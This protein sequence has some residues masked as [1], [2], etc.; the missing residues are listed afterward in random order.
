MPEIDHV[1]VLMLEN[2]SFDHILGFLDHPD[3]GFD[4]VRGIGPYV[5]PGWENNPEVP[6]TPTAKTVI[7]V[8]PDH[9]HAGVMEQLA[10][11]GIGASRG[12]TNQGF[13]T[14]YERKCRGGIPGEYGGLFSPL[15]NWWTRR[16]TNDNQG[17][18]GRGP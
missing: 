11:R 16:G 3:P 7:P 8:G 6:A 9:T 4:G 12:P 5:N 17:I 14:S 13:V 10:V 2:R 18:S 15:A 1:I